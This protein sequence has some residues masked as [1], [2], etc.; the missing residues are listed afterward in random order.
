MTSRVAIIGLDCFD[1]TLVFD[2]WR[3]EL[4]N[5]S[6]LMAQGSWGRL[7][8]TIP[9]ITVPAWTAMMSGKNPGTLG[10]YGFRNRADYSYDRMMIATSNA[11]SDDRAW[12]I[13]SRE[14][15]RVIVLGV[16]QTYPPK[17]VNGIMVTSFLTPSKESQYTW[18]SEFRDEI[19]RVTPDYMLDVDDF[20]TE[21]KLWLLEEIYKMTENRFSLARHLVATKP[22]D[23]FMMV[24]MGPDRLHHGFWRYFDR[25]H[26]K[27]EPGN[28]YENV[29]LKYYQYIDAQIGQLLELFD[30]DT[31]VMVVSD[32]GSQ[33]MDGGICVNEW[34]M[35]EG[36][37]ALR[38]SPTEVTPIN[39]LQIDWARTKAWGSGGYYARLFLNVEGREPQGV[40]PADAYER[41]RDE[42]VAKLEA[43]TDPGGN[44]I[45]TRAFK[46]QDIYKQVKGIPPD[47]IVYFGNLSWRSVGSVGY[48]SYYTFEN[49]TGPDDANHAQHGL[50]IL[51]DPGREPRG[52]MERLHITDVAPSVLE[53][54]DLHVPEDME[55]KVIE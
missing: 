47:L 36:Y 6:R 23:F 34:L 14:G 40:V 21:S 16:P 4:P 46:P 28:K 53:M 3:A 19:D 48:G 9:P 13:L 10:F 12:E 30:E 52:E 44:N 22:W 8:S 33:K 41:T 51:R 55:G 50:F 20:R 11:I 26:P 17:E 15:K 25:S 29:G 38:E 2:L 37:L 1:P 42:L 39:K 27:Y 32:H 45:G 43:I 5:L 35:Q 54:F 18:P 31:A 7:E 24:S 49:D